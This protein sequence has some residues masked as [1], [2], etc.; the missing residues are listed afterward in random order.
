MTSLMQS[1]QH[2]RVEFELM[3]TPATVGLISP[4]VELRVDYHHA[5]VALA[6]YR[7]WKCSASILACSLC[8]EFPSSVADEARCDLMDEGARPS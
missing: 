2:H 3:S 5:C 6:Q 8:Q 1:H 7:T 4:R